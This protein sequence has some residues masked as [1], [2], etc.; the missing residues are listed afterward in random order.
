MLGLLRLLV[1]QKL[2]EGGS[3]L[4][5]AT[6]SASVNGYNLPPEHSN[7]QLQQQ[8]RHQHQQQRQIASSGNAGHAGSSSCS[9]GGPPAASPNDPAGLSAAAL[10]A[11]RGVGSRHHLLGSSPTMR[12]RQSHDPGPGQELPL[13]T[14]AVTI[15][16]SP[17]EQLTPDSTSIPRLSCA[18]VCWAVS[19]PAK[20]L[21][22]AAGA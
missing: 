4:W 20:L 7:P 19:F 22:C 21:G 2:A 10:A 5:V 13:L 18:A 12:L 1:V 8:L 14:P 3:K 16:G 6:T 11:G 9:S 17:G 15:A